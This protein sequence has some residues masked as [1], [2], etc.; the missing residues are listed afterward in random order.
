MKISLIS[1]FSGAGA[2]DYAFDSTGQFSVDVSVEIEPSF[3]ETIRLN[4]QSGL[5]GDGRLIEADVSDLSPT[6]VTR[7]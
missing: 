6:D 3:C 1:L 7:N 4:K 5:L 2:L